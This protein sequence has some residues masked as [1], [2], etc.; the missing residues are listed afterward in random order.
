YSYQLIYS[1]T[2]TENSSALTDHDIKL[3]KLLDELEQSELIKK[4]YKKP[5][6]P[7]EFF[8]KIF[9]KKLFDYI[10]PKIDKKLSSI[11]NLLSGKPLYLMSKEGWPVEESVNIAEEPASVLFHFRRNDEE[12]RYFPTIKFKGMRIDFMY[13]NAQVITHEPALLLLEGTLYFFDQDL[14]GKKLSP[15]LNKRFISI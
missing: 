1:K 14:D 3:I 9:D 8:S 11:L 2:T 10:R 6:R 5:I 4:M 7:R 15:F 13:K 12:T